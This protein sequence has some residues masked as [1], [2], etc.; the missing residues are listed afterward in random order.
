MIPLN[1]THVRQTF[2]PGPAITIVDD[3]IPAS[4]RAHQIRVRRRPSFK[5]NDIAFQKAATLC[6]FQFWVVYITNTGLRRL[7]HDS[8]IFTDKLGSINCGRPTQ[9]CRDSMADFLKGSKLPGENDIDDIKGEMQH[10]S[11]GVHHFEIN[12]T[13]A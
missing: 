6:R 8:P 3:H 9:P 5:S 2:N 12:M 13:A 7:R 10:P 4:D 11:P 1:E